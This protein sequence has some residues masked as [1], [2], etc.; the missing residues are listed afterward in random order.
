MFS[1][2]AITPVKQMLRIA[3][4]IVL[5]GLGIGAGCVKIPGRNTRKKNPGTLLNRDFHFQK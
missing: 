3:L 1:V 2:P 4:Q 5:S